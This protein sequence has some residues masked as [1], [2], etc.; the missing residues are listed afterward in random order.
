MPNQGD[1]VDKAFYEQ[2]AEDWQLPALVLI[3]EIKYP[4]ITGNTI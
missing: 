1:E 2:L 3:E 4:D